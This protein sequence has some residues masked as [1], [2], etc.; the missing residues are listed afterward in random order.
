MHFKTRFLLGVASLVV[1]APLS[2]TP[3]ANG[4][5]AGPSPCSAALDLWATIT[6]PGTG[7]FSL[8]QN[9]SIGGF[10]GYLL[11][12][13]ARNTTTNQLDF[14]YQVVSRPTST[15][16]LTRVASDAFA[17]FTTNVG[18][19]TFDVDGA[20]AMFGDAGAAGQ[21]PTSVDRTATGSLGFN[22]PA[23]IAG[24]SL[25]AG[26][27]SHTIVVRTNATNYV[28]NSSFQVTQGGTTSTIT[29]MIA[30][31]AVPEPGTYMLI[32]AGLVAL[33]LW[34]RAHQ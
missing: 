17:P 7:L 5:C 27:T 6:N 26:E 18:Y 13:V 2:A 14:Y 23:S 15:N 30:P 9:F 4:Q 25:T 22:F 8:Q 10:D 11:S 34:R 20:V 19:V 1:A 12:R 31:T 28:M 3:I 32:G 33:G 24:A 29:G 16:A 21:A